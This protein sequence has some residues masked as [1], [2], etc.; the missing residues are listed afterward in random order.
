MG[1]FSPHLSK[2]ATRIDPFLGSLV[3]NDP[4][5]HGVNGFLTKKP[6]PASP[7][8]PPT[9]DTASNASA[10]QQQALL[11]RRGILGNV[12]AGD[13]STSAPAT[14]SKSALGT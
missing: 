8:A 14:A 13:A 11:R 1:L 6:P 3:R 7:L 10:Q 5:F 4:I 12:Y 2:V 9:E